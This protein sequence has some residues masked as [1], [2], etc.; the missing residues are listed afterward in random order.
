M[1]LIIQITILC[2]RFSSSA[3][4][5]LFDKIINKNDRSLEEIRKEF[6]KASA[7][8][9]ANAYQEFVETWDETVR[10]KDSQ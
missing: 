9:T 8:I 2:I 6:G 10:D 5:S 3:T 1:L 4:I 7:D